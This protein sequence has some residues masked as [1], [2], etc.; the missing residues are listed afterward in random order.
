MRKID[1]CPLCDQ[2][3]GLSRN[4]PRRDSRHHVF[5]RSFYPDSTLVVHVCWTCHDEFN[6]DYQNKAKHRWSKI[7]CIRIW[8]AFCFMKG[9]N[10]Y[11]V[12]PEL[13]DLKPLL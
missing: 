8:I 13:K 2:P 1:C 4:H 5:P 10:A 6:R 9:K 12:Y 7:E 3:Y 11:D